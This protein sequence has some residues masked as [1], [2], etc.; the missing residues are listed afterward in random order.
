[1][2]QCGKMRVNFHFANDVEVRYG[3]GNYHAQLR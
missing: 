3:G 1:M 2:N